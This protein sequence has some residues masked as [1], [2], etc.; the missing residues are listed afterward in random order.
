MFDLVQDKYLTDIYRRHEFYSEDMQLIS[1]IDK[2]EYWMEKVDRVQFDF[3]YNSLETSIE[4]Y[5]DINY[6]TL[7]KFQSIIKEYLND[8][9][10]KT[11]MKNISKKSAKNFLYLIPT[12]EEYSPNINIDADTGYV[13]ITFVTKDYGLLSA[14]IT[15]KSEIHY[16]RVSRGVKIYKISGVAKIKDSRDFKHFSKILGML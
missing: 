5:F 2:E 14:L 3:V 15:E 12:I 9:S 16:S 6:T 4:K 10:T 8:K 7:T 11:N 1:R 13:N